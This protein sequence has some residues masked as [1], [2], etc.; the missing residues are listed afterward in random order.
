LKVQDQP[1]GSKVTGQPVKQEQLKSWGDGSYSSTDFIYS[2]V[3]FAPVKTRVCFY[4]AVDRVTKGR[5]L[6]HTPAPR[7][8]KEYGRIFKLFAGFTIR[9]TRFRITEE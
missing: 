1:P 6:V 4:V 3:G 7:F 8:L 2:F 9:I 5:G